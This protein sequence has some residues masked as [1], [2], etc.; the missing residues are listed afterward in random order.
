M[1]AVALAMAM[2]VL[3]GCGGKNQPGPAG[4][5]ASIPTTAT[6]P[7]PATSAA[8]SGPKA[9]GDNEMEWKIQVDGV[10]VSGT[11]SKRSD[12]GDA[13]DGLAV[14]LAGT[15]ANIA[16]PATPKGQFTNPYIVLALKSVANLD[17]EFSFTQE[18]VRS[19]ELAA[20]MG[21]DTQRS[22]RQNQKTVKSL[23][24]KGTW[25]KTTRR[26]AGTA[27]GVWEGAPAEGGFLADGQV[28]IRFNVTVPAPN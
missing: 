2:V 6:A 20:G 7:V 15:Q 27:T 5:K 10:T 16:C 21:M 1:R 22:L 28:E 13:P 9:L 23:A 12:A 26:L 11:C 17:P 8:P 3:A 19:F 14:G 24:V 4:A 18:N 25:D